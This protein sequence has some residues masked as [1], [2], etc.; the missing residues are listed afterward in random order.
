MFSNRS[1]AEQQETAGTE[2]IESLYRHGLMLT[3]NESDAEGLV[4]ETYL[5]ALPA[6]G[7]SRQGSNI[8]SWLFTILRNAWLNYCRRNRSQGQ[9][10]DHDGNDDGTSNLVATSKGPYDEYVC[11]T[12]CS[13]V[14]GAIEQLPAEFREIIT[15][16]DFERLADHEIVEMLE[17]P[18]G[19]VVSRSARARSKLRIQLTTTTH[20][21]LPPVGEDTK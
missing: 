21:Y 7:K 12:E 4:Q 19:T 6:M 3:R 11:K 10:L 17:C 1:T 5:P 9:F 20:S 13:L 14:R 15:L 8:K 18:P 16:R 2:H